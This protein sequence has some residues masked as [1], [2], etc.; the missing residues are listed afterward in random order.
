M[1]ALVKRLLYLWCALGSAY[2]APERVL[3]VVTSFTVLKDFVQIIGGKYVSV[4]S[5]VGPNGDP[6]TY[7]PTPSDVQ[8]IAAADVIFVNGLH[9]D[10]WFHKLIDA[11]AN[12]GLVAVASSG[13]KK[14]YV[15]EGALTVCDPH[16]WHDPLNAL[17]YV[18]NI[19]QVLC[20]QDPDHSDFYQRNARSYK[21]QI[22][23]LHHVIQGVFSGLVGEAR[24]VMTAH[25]GFGYFGRAYDMIF[26]APM[27]MSTEEETRPQDMVF[28]IKM[29]RKIGVRT[30]FAE[31]ITNDKVLQQ[32]AREGGAT[33][34]EDLFSDSL[35]DAD[36]PAA[37]YLNML[38]HNARVIAQSK[39]HLGARPDLL[40][41]WQESIVPICAYG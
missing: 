19:A 17:V 21:E 20:Q 22:L 23:M 30:V 5:V 10:S 37:T 4:T 40:D 39:R 15:K 12:E 11:S 6:H 2:A 41:K 29:I 38:L 25:E 26:Y 34:G 18:D 7:T 36:G 16:A 9:L 3:N 28:L 13:V 32:I 33:I 27:G 1:G 35:S 31:S 14:R 8:R 24:V